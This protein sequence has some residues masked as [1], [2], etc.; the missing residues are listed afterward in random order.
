MH[1]IASLAELVKWNIHTPKTLLNP[2]RSKHLG[3][4]D[5][6]NMKVVIY[7]EKPTLVKKLRDPLLF[8]ILIITCY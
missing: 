1:T 5:V 6:I 7:I 2:C 4:K 8:C 3:H